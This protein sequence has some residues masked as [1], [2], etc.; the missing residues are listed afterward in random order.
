[1]KEYN[2]LIETNSDSWMYLAYSYEF[3]Q[4]SL[5]STVSEAVRISEHHGAKKAMDWIFTNLQ[6]KSIKIIKAN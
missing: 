5:V 1:M 2:I 3:S 4:Y 6:F